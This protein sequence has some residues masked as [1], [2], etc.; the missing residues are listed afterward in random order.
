MRRR[1][2]RVRTTIGF[3]VRREGGGRIQKFDNLAFFAPKFAHGGVA[4]GNCALTVHH[5][6]M[7]IEGRFS[8]LARAS[9]GEAQLSFHTLDSFMPR[10]Y[11]QYSAIYAVQTEVP[12]ILID[13]KRVGWRAGASLNLREP[14][15]TTKLRTHAFFSNEAEREI[16]RGPS[17]P[18]L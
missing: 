10:T 8:I 9:T 15:I 4:K 5:R 11:V 18:F 7:G 6:N 14:R 13:K 1:R 3:V 17:H 16:E 12:T 2:R